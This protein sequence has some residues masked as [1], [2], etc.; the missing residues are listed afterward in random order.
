[1]FFFLFFF[2]SSPTIIVRFCSCFISIRPWLLNNKKIHI[3][4]ILFIV[5]RERILVSSCL[6][7]RINQKFSSFFSCFYLVAENIKIFIFLFSPMF[8][9]YSYTYIHISEISH[10]LY[11][12]VISKTPSFS[13]YFSLHTYTYIISCAFIWK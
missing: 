5:P 1:M 10:A 4:F 13:L 9:F 8:N 2:S 7:I 6:W 11:E 3:W 12:H